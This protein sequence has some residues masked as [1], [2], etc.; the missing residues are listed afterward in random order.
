MTK[1]QPTSM[2]TE[3]ILKTDPTKIAEGLNNYFPSIAEKLQI[4]QSI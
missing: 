1:G 3:N 2:I 4:F